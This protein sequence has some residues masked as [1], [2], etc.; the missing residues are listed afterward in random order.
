MVDTG[1]P[2]DLTSKV[3]FPG[4]CPIVAK[5]QV[6]LHTANGN[7]KIEHVMETAIRELQRKVTPY[8]LDNTPDV[9]SIGDRAM[10]LGSSFIWMAGRRPVLRLPDGAGEIQLMVIQ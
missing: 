9:L 1:C 8:L 2:Y 3:S 5:E 6:H 10:R 4:A 7:T